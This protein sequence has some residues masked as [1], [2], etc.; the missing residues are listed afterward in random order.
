MDVPSTTA[1]L[2][3]VF[4]DKYFPDWVGNILDVVLCWLYDPWGNLTHLYSQ[5]TLFD[6]VV[7]FGD[8]F[9][10]TWG[11]LLVMDLFFEAGFYFWEER[12]A[13]MGCWFVQ[14]CVYWWD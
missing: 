14:I 13:L 8:W 10:F 6:V 9:T 7:F 2:L 12:V 1:N 11:L 3:L 5:L 4:V